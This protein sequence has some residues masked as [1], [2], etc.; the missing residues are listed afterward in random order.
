MIE[1][2][3]CSHTLQELYQLLVTLFYILQEVKSDKT[4]LMMAVE[5]KDI[6]VVE[7]F[8]QTAGVLKARELVNQQTRAGNSS[9]HIAAGL[10]Y[11]AEN[12]KKQ[13]LSLLIRFGG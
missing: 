5:S 4:P 6:R 12:I 7:L 9:L 11:V 3:K 1:L 8:L 10:Q 13:L 2:L